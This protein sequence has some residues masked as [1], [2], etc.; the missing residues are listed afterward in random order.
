MFTAS[1]SIRGALGLHK[2][3]I[4]KGSDIKSNNDANDKVLT[5]Q[6]KV[7]NYRFHYNYHGKSNMLRAAKGLW[8]PYIYRN[9]GHWPN[10]V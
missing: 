6:L 8:F 10:C 7:V 9:I 1:N 5:N 4:S 2:E 3:K